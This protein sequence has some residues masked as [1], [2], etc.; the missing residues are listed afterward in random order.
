MRRRLPA[1]GLALA[2]VLPSVVHGLDPT[3]RPEGPAQ[4]GELGP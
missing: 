4:D 2:L 3:I 1:D